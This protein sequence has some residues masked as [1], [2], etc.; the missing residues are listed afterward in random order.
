MYKT[1]EEQKKEQEYIKQYFKI[2]DY[3]QQLGYTVKRIGHYYTLKEHD[4]VRINPEKNCFW[5]NSTSTS[6]SI[7]DF[8][9]HFGNMT[10]SGAFKFFSDQLDGNSTFSVTATAAGKTTGIR[11]NTEVTGTQFILPEKDKTMRNVFAYLI[12]QRKIDKTVVEYWVRNKNLYQDMRKNCVFVG[13]NSEGKEVFVCKRG[14]LSDV[15]YMGDV[16]GSDYDW[17]IYIDHSAEN[18]IVCESAIDVMSLMSYMVRDN[19]SL[20]NY[21]YLV[22][23][24]TNKYQSLFFHL[25]RCREPQ[26]RNVCIA[27]DNDSAGWKVS[28]MIQNKLSM[29]KRKWEVWLP[30]LNDW[31]DD[32]KEDIDHAFC[33]KK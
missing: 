5:Q 2:T 17:C 24:S 31:N 15:R 10:V 23:A 26:N 22:L 1:K 21:N 27:L 11:G 6:G 3:A 25:E 4:S 33:W 12:Q 32:W 30:K 19:I 13:F 9:I 16:A 8:A 20:D 18:L 14:T 28:L 29:M 7:I